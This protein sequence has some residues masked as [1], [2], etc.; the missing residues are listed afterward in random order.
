MRSRSVDSRTCNHTSIYYILLPLSSPLLPFALSSNVRVTVLPALNHAS[1]NRKTGD[2]HIDD[3]S[4]VPLQLLL[5]LVYGQV[6]LVKA[7]VRPREDTFL[8]ADTLNVEAPEVAII[9]LQRLPWVC[10]G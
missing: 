10:V 1:I 5:C 8:P 3:Q 7:C 4:Q 9:R 6:Q 2:L